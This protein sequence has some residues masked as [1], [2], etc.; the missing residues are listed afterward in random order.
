MIND[1]KP[2]KIVLDLTYFQDIKSVQNKIEETGIVCVCGMSIFKEEWAENALFITD[3][4]IKAEE[5]KAFNAAVLIYLHEG[6]KEQHF[7]L[8]RYFIEGFEEVDAI[9]FK[10][11]YQREKNIPR[12]IGETENLWI[13]EMSIEDTDALYAL[14]EDKSVVKFM[15]DLPGNKEEEK[16]YIADYIDKVYGFLEFGM[17]IVIKKD[18]GEIIGR[19]GFQNSEQEDAAELGFMII[20]FYQGRGYG[21]EACD[22]AVSYMKEEFPQIRL[23]AKCHKENAAAIAL[24]EKLKINCKLL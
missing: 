24:C 20:P 23:M 18:T 6:N 15:D 3:D 19:V 5:F 2:E 16:E 17:W 7:P 14:Y 21:F 1:K 8:N 11:I 9:Y 4:S 12:I 10:R 13:R 22:I